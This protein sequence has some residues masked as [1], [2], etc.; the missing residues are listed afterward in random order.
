MFGI[1]GA[2]RQSDVEGNLFDVVCQEFN[3]WLGLGY[4]S[5]SKVTYSMI[6]AS[7]LQIYFN[8]LAIGKVSFVHNV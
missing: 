2:V 1:V 6:Q 7:N 3:I 4:Q 8:R 5:I